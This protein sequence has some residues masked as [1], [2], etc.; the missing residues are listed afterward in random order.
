MPEIAITKRHLSLPWAVAVSA[1]VGIISGTGVYYT[2]KGDVQAARSKVE[3]VQTQ[4]ASWE[5]SG[6]E[7]FGVVERRVERLEETS[8]RTLIVLERIDE[9]TAEMKRRLDA[10]PAR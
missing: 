6:R 1:V 8:Q 9:R 10:A 7:R 5:T 4:A 3:A 2:L